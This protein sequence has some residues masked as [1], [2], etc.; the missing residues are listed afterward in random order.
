[1]ATS[2]V[3][4][5]AH[6]PA[7]APILNAKDEANKHTESDKRNVKNISGKTIYLESGILNSGDVGV[8]TLAEFQALYHTHIELE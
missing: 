2:P 6:K 7:T 4:K 5:P 3:T 1:M 8:A